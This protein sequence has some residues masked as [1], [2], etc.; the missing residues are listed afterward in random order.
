MIKQTKLLK[1][2]L[3][4]EKIDVSRE[5]MQILVEKSE[6]SSPTSPKTQKSVQKLKITQKT[7]F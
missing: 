1:K 7:D 3:L 5:E 6:N 4:K 2:Q